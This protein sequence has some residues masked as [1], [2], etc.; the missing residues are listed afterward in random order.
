MKKI[1]AIFSAAVLLIIV[2]NVVIAVI[3]N[4]IADSVRKDL[5]K[6]P[7]PENTQIISSASAAGKVVGNGNGMQYFGAVL[8]KSELPLEQL[9]L[10]YSKYNYEV[11]VQTDKQINVIDHGSYSFNIKGDGELTDHYIVYGFGHLKKGNFS[12]ILEQFDLRGH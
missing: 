4:G 3:N 7:L 10:Y 6:T 2:F 11:A 9:E 1:T 5:I 8:V 12:D